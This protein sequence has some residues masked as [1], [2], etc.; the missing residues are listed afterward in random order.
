[1]EAVRA[2]VLV[3]AHVDEELPIRNEYLAAENSNL[4]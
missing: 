1:M 4:K 3:G 2:M